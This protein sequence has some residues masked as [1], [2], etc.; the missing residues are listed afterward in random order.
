[1]NKSTLVEFTSKHPDFRTRDDKPRF[2]TPIN[3]NHR[4]R[5]FLVRSYLEPAPAQHRA[6]ALFKR[7]DSDDQGE[8]EHWGFYVEN[9]GLVPRDKVVCDSETSCS[10]SEKIEAPIVKEEEMEIDVE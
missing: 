2:L 5:I 8:I 1:M 10:L 6:V 4:P 3:N 7:P 9:V